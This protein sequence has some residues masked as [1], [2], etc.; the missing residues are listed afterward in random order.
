MFESKLNRRNAL[1]TGAA[2]AGASAANLTM[3]AQAWAQSA[4]WKPEK[5]A[6]ISL[7]RFI[8]GPLYASTGPGRPPPRGS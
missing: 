7:L 2:L 6:A 3:F 5:G 1:K 4:P 8:P